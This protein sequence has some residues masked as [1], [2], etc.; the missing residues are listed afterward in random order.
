MSSVWNMEQVLLTLTLNERTSLV[1]SAHIQH[2][3]SHHTLFITLN[4]CSMVLV[5]S[6]KHLLQVGEN[7]PWYSNMLWP[8]ACSHYRK[9]ENLKNN[10]VENLDCCI[11]DRI[12]IYLRSKGRISGFFIWRIIIRNTERE[13]KE[14]TALLLQQRN[15][16]KHLGSSQCRRVILVMFI[17]LIYSHSLKWYNCDI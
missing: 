1:V 12:C 3:F 9:L 14:F 6:G 13:Q 17:R 10:W 16:I 7:S 8:K 4:S 2:F 5:A 15:N 11:I